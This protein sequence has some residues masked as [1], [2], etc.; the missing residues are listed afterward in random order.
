MID[1]L[2]DLVGGLSTLIGWRLAVSVAVGVVGCFALYLARGAVAGDSW[3]L[4]SILFVATCAGFVWEI[5][6]QRARCG[7]NPRK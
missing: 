7:F 6:T 2:P 4:G 3:A 5:A 1:G